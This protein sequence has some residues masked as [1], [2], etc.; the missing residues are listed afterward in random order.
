[1]TG[2]KGSGFGAVSLNQTTD[3]LFLTMPFYEAREISTTRHLDSRS[4]LG[5]LRFNK[6]PDSAK[7]D[8]SPQNGAT[9]YS[10]ETHGSYVTKASLNGKMTPIDD[11]V[12]FS[13]D[14]SRPLAGTSLLDWSGV[15]A[16]K[17][18]DQKAVVLHPSKGVFEWWPSMTAGSYFINAEDPGGDIYTWV[19]SISSSGL[20]KT[21]RETPGDFTQPPLTLWMDRTKGGWVGMYSPPRG[22]RRFLY[23]ATLSPDAEGDFFAEGW[24][25]TEVTPTA[26]TGAWR[27]GQSKWSR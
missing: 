4:L 17:F 14:H 13:T 21:V 12:A 24:I 3:Q 25:E 11:A 27:A 5:E 6:N 8:V 26:R 9:P 20:I 1:M 16:F 22:A 15:R 7:W 10:L 2:Y 18:N 23:G 19:I